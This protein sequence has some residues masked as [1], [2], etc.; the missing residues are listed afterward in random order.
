MIRD[1][2]PE[3]NAIE[4]QVRAR[5]FFGQ[6]ELP[7]GR[8]HAAWVEISHREH[9]PSPITCRLKYPEPLAEPYVVP[10]GA[11][12]QLL[13][14]FEPPYAGRLRIHA[15]GRGNFQTHEAILYPG[16]YDLLDPQ[17]S[18]PEGSQ[19]HAV[20]HLTA[21][22]LL[23]HRFNRIIN[24]DGT[25][26]RYGQDWPLL[27]W[28]HDNV[29]YWLHLGHESSNVLEG[30]NRAL[31][32]AQRPVLRAKLVQSN[33][34]S[35]AELLERVAAS[36]EL[37]LILFSLLSRRTI[38]WFDLS[39][40]IQTSTGERIE[41]RRRIEPR[42]FDPNDRDE[43]PL[44]D[45]HDLGEGVF[46]SMLVAL[47]EFERHTDLVR[48]VRYLLGSYRND[49]VDTN[50]LLAVSAFE[51]LINALEAAHPMEDRLGVEWR[52]LLGALRRVVRCYCRR[53]RLDDSVAG[54][55]QSKLADLRRMSFTSKA[56]YHL[57]RLE[58]D[59]THLWL[60]YHTAVDQFAEGL[61][62]AYRTRSALVHNTSIAD[63]GRLISDLARIQSLLERT[64][65]RLLGGP[66]PHI[67]EGLADARYR[68][69]NSPSGL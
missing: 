28:T 60:N 52:V 53:R 29:E 63:L 32:L 22:G 19:I 43:L 14:S 6:L 42:F 15:L 54:M 65:M 35:L 64:V 26:E 8:R 55:L 30:S 38:E 58:V 51:T 4:D 36:L 47:T 49:T 39:L 40:Y 21:K 17:L 31:L 37:P 13:F 2:F 16:A 62:A 12:R 10:Y 45:E 50:F 34:E 3:P 11:D 24:Q 67:S 7:E 33:N 20:A 23:L 61:A 48:S 41:A 68:S 9:S 44:L 27:S 1:P 59:T 66:K 57:Q 69:K 18:I 46:T 5:T 25:I 56:R